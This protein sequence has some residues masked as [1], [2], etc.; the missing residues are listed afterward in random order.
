MTFTL[1]LALPLS[2]TVKVRLAIGDTNPDAPMCSDEL[3]A[4]QIATTGDWQSAAIACLNTVIAE[5]SAIPDFKADWL[6]VDTA[7]GIAAL[8]VLLNDLKAGYG[9]HVMITSASVQ[10]VVWGGGSR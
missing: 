1:S 4:A 9:Q 7:S 5:M 3:I 10:G 6:Q 2:D 8:R